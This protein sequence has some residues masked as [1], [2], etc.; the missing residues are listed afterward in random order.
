VRPTQRYIQNDKWMPCKVS[1]GCGIPLSTQ[2][3][4]GAKYQSPADTQ[5]SKLNLGHV[6][7]HKS[8]C[9]LHCHKIPNCSLVECIVRMQEVGFDLN[10]NAIGHTQLQLVPRSRIRGSIHP[11]PYPFSWHTRTTLP[12]PSIGH[13]AF[14]LVENLVTETSCLSTEWVIWLAFIGE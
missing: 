1:L 3:I 8:V 7:K 11:H 12:L 2:D 14:W 5:E 9:Q 13:F 6:I 4:Y 10:A